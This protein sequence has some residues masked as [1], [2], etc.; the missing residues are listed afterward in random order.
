MPVLLPQSGHFTVF[1][2]VDAA[3]VG[4]ARIAPDHGVM[5]RG[6]AARLQQAALNREARIVEIEI[7]RHAPHRVAV[8][9]F[10]VHAMQ[11]H[12]IA[13]PRKGVAL[14]VGVVEVQHAALGH[15]GVV[16]KVLLQPLPQLH[17]K[18]VK[19]NVA[20]K[21]VVRADDRRVAPGVAGADPA[22]FHHRNIADAELLGQ[23][24][25]GRQVHARRRRR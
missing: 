3:L 12:C 1:D 5:A 22:F 8:E 14:A 17:A 20:G 9:Q 2:D 16:V 24:M 18:F 11:A 23:I 21:Q 4:G 13:A 7:G 19:R 25:R 15:H 10:G 6:A